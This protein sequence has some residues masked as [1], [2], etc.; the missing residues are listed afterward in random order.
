MFNGNKNMFVPVIFTC[1]KC[2][3]IV[4][5]SSS[6]NSSFVCFNTLLNAPYLGGQVELPCEQ[7]KR[8]LLYCLSRPGCLR[9]IIQNTS[10]CCNSLLLC[11]CLFS[12]SSTQTTETRVSLVWVIEVA[13]WGKSAEL[14]IYLFIFFTANP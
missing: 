14:F 5:P 4:V 12:I 11:G 3:P 6:Q 10:V 9:S 7:T 13:V 1:D 2:S 8:G